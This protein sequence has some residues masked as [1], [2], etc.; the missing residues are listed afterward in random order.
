MT[1]TDGLV[2]GIVYREERPDYQDELP[3]YDPKPLV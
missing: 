1:E 2:T 3:N